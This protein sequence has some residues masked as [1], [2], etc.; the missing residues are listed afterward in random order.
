MISP[1]RVTEIE[2]VCLLCVVARKD[3]TS[4]SWLGRV[5]VTRAC[6]IDLQHSTVDFP[7][8]YR[9]TYCTCL[10]QP[11]PEEGDLTRSG[12]NPDDPRSKYRCKVFQSWDE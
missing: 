9:S 12:Y 7:P 10:N 1:T 8:A 4:D 3:S 6:F 5:V 2:R 11:Y